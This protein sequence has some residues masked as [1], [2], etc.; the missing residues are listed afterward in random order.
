[1]AIT[2]TTEIPAA[3]SEFYDKTLLV[4]ALPYLVH[5]KFGQRRP[6]PT[7]QSKVIKFRKYN[8]LAVATTPL[9]EGVTPSS[10]QLAKTD[11]SATVAQYGAFVDVTDMVTLTNVEPVLT[12]AAE[13]LGEQAGESLDE[14][15]RAVLVA[16]TNVAYANA[17]ADRNSVVTIV[18]TADLDKVIRVLSNN[19]AKMHTKMIKAG[20]GI[21]TQPIRPAFWAIVH[22]DV[23]FT[24]DGLTGFKSVETYSS[25]GA[26]QPNE[27]GAYKNIRFVMSTKAKIWTGAGAT[28]GGFKNTAGEVDVYAMLIFGTD[29][30]GI[31]EIRGNGLKNY[32]KPLGSAGTAD[33]LNQVA[34]S[35]WK[36]VTVCKI[37]NDSF[38]LR[39]ETA[40]AL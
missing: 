40:A 23:A 26:V 4:R 30:Y 20:T 29:A 35:G 8:A 15:Y 13:L 9:S 11:I 10:N 21:G 18:T 31:S 17:V 24:L 37:L 19:M 27:I 3:V 14:I 38:M 28:S 25:Q 36:A 16:G 6:I 2:T 33:P 22:P 7:G 12:E 1:M 39:L 34:T 5:D 32:V